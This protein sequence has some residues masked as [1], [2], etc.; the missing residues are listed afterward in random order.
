MVKTNKNLEEIYTAMFEAARCDV[1]FYLVL[2]RLIE[3]FDGAA[4]VIF[5]LNRKTGEISNWVG[6]GLEPGELEYAEKLNAI[7]PRMR[8]SLSHAAGHVCYEYLFTDEEKMDNSEFYQAIERLSGVRYFLGSRMYDVGDVSV[9]H[10][11]EFTRQ[12]GHPDKQ[13]IEAFRRLSKNLGQAWKF[14]R[15]ETERPANGPSRLF[16]DHLPWA[17]FTASSDGTS[18]PQNGSAMKL[19]APKGPFDLHEGH[20]QANDDTVSEAI[21]KL[22]K[23]GLSGS[24]GV[25]KIPDTEITAQKIVQVIPVPDSSSATL[26]IRNTGQSFDHFEEVLP[27]L[28]GLTANEVEIVK[29]LARGNDL[30]AVAEES[31]RSRNTVRNHLQKIYQKA[32]VNNRAE[33]LVQVLGLLKPLD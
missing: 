11:V 29:S 5:E 30:S 18:Q 12:Q 13:K 14:S 32:N 15:A 27:I 33:L 8:Y 21:A 7:N 23:Q 1:S 28:Y 31:G 17:V 24:A 2:N 22:I 6:P 25:M 19:V 16:Y 3:Y 4:G 26:F 20:L 10:S 9:F